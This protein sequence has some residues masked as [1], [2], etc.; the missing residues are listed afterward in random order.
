MASQPD[1]DPD[2]ESLIQRIRERSKGRRV[3]ARHV[4]VEMMA[5]GEFTDEELQRFALAGLVKV[6]KDA[7]AQVNPTTGVPDFETVPGTALHAQIDM[8]TESEYEARI[9]EL[10]DLSRQDL[11]RVVAR[12]DYFQGRWHRMP[13]LPPWFISA[14]GGDI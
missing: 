14:M 7:L 13:I 8:F 6:A 10:L 9:T 3:E 4:I 2:R 5:D 1:L 12:V 11:R